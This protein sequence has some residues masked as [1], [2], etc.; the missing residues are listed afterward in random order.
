[1]KENVGTLV[2]VGWNVVGCYPTE[3]PL[4]SGGRAGMSPRGG[5]GAF[6]RSFGL[7]R[8]STG[9]LHYTITRLIVDTTT[10]LNTYTSPRANRS[11]ASL[12]INFL[13]SGQYIGDFSVNFCVLHLFLRE[14][15]KKNSTIFP[16]S[17]LLLPTRSPN[18][19]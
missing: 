16:S 13:A 17:C 3:N 14:I 12:E 18:V 11:Q 10:L 4:A 2:T 7:P 15:Q 5:S 8:L 1:M 19:S 6:T 9:G